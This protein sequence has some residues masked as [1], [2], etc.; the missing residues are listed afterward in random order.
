VAQELLNWIKA[1]G[2]LVFSWPVAA[3][4]IVLVFR[5]SLLELMARLTASEQGKAEIGPVR[6]EL[7]NLAK[8]GRIAVDKLNRLNILMAE[9]RL[10][11]LEITLSRFG[12]G[13]SV[14]QGLEWNSRS[15][16]SAV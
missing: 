10:L 9:S 12:A 7:G 15:K 4:L 2:P 1:V 6:I 14:E 8:E 3:I 13:F 5:R 16:S 11:E